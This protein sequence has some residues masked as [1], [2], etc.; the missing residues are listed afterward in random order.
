MI[1]KMVEK[2]N[3]SLNIVGRQRMGHSKGQPIGKSMEH[4]DYMY[5]ESDMEDKE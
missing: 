4:I 3:M 2:L 5:V 1:Y